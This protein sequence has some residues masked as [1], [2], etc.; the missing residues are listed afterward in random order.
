MGIR[1]A[2]PA[3]RW[4]RPPGWTAALGSA[5]LLVALAGAC[6]GSPSQT[7]I[8]IHNNS[9]VT[10][11]QLAVETPGSR[12]EFGELGPGAFTEYEDFGE[13]YSYAY[14]STVIDG[15][16]YVLQPID[17]TG[18]QPLGAG[19]FTY[20]ITILDPQQRILGMTASADS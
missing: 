20:S 2:A 17:Y 11:T 5:G 13:S 15:Q 6:T 1:R 10:F 19:R 9:G 12:H 14:V 3:L 8:R 7:L 4:G 16:A 18:E